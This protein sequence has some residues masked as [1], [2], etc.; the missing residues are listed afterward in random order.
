M[1]HIVIVTFDVLLPPGGGD[2]L[3]EGLHLQI[4]PADQRL[5]HRGLAPT[6]L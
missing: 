5:Q 2:P 4:G 6:G 3:Q 1:F